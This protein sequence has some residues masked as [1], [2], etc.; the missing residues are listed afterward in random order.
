[1]WAMIASG[2]LSCCAHLAFGPTSRSNYCCNSSFRSARPR[3]LRRIV[4]RLLRRRDKVRNVGMTR[5]YVARYA[6]DLRHTKASRQI[7]DTG[8]GECNECIR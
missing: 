4:R 5:R 6:E 1:M 8:T 7:I 2:M 3:R